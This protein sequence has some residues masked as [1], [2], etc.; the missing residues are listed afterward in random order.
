MAT[1]AGFPFL[2][3]KTIEGRRREEYFA[4]V[5]AGMDRNYRPMEKIF[6]RVLK[7]SFSS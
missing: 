3:F 1:Q 4:A 6:S 5:R 7:Q 2:N